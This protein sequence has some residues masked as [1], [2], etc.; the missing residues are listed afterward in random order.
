MDALPA[1]LPTYLREGIAY[2]RPGWLRRRVRHLYRRAHPRIAAL[3]GGRLRVLPQSAT[4]HYLTRVVAGVRYYRPDVPIVLLTPPP[5]RSHDYP[6]RRGHAASVAAA[7][8]GARREQV[9]LADIDDV[10]RDMHDQGA[11]NPDG[12]HWDWPTHQR[13]ADVVA[14]ALDF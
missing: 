5:W 13:V 10:V 12:L 9:V 8:A 14:A 6:G 4:D 2:V 3:W 7:R 11:G 1:S